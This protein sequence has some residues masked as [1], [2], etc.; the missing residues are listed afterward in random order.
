MYTTCVYYCFQFRPATPDVRNGTVTE[1]T[2]AS[3]EATP[4]NKDGDDDSAVRENPSA[5]HSMTI[6]EL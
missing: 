1:E 4:D 2:A 3:C 5:G 6:K